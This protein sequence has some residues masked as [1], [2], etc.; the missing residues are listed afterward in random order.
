VI[1]TFY[2]HG[3]DSPATGLSRAQI[4]AALNDAAGVLWL[5]VENEPADRNAD[6]LGLVGLP[7]HLLTACT[8]LQ[9]DEFLHADARVVAFRG[10][11]VPGEGAAGTLTA[12][13]GPNY[14]ITL[15]AAPIG[16]IERLRS[17]I[18]SE[19]GPPAAGSHW[20]LASLVDEI[21]SDFDAALND[22]NSRLARVR[23]TAAK[24]PEQAIRNDLPAI[25]KTLT[26]YG[27]ATASLAHLTHRLAWDSELQIADR[28]RGHYRTAT[29]AFSRLAERTREAREALTG[30]L[31][32]SQAVS[33]ARTE[34]RLARLGILLGV[35]LP[36]LLVAT[37]FG[38]GLANV[39]G[40]ARPDAWVVVV[41]VMALAGLLGALIVWPGRR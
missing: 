23:A 27:A 18:G 10:P 15:H 9:P 13:T 3:E 25:A 21:R 8:S 30:E 19:S 34:Q 11:S 39:P 5:D 4:S 41:I 38:M 35:V 31:V 14:L 16:G 24:S 28:H 26:T 40:T 6:L 17:G 7:S 2:Y 12:V 33:A 32:L 36:M 22:A 20:L 37:F 29:T 1:H